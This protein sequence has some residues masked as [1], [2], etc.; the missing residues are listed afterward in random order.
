MNEEFLNY[1]EMAKVF[2]AK[3]ERTNYYESKSIS[4]P[5]PEYALMLI[6]LSDEEVSKIKG[7]KKYYGEDFVNHLDEVINDSDVV[8]D[9]FC[10][11][12]VDID[13][14]NI[15]HQYVFNIRTVRGEEVTSRKILVEL[16]DEDYCKLLAWHLYDSHLVLNTLFYRDEELCRKIMR[17]SMRWVCD[18]LAPMVTDP[19]VLTMD[20]A[21]ADTELIRQENNLTKSTGFLGLF[22]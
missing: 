13:L 22:F 21:L 6:S 7:L 10:G 20:E 2:L 19:F 17:E 3:K 18:D 12:P 5:Y 8:D 16:S 9:M 15:H 4:E 14:E 1:Q 11:D